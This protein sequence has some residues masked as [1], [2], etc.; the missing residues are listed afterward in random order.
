MQDLIRIHI[1]FLPFARVNF[2]PLRCSWTALCLFFI[3]WLVSE[4]KSIA[5]KHKSIR[6]SRARWILHS[7]I[8]RI[9][10]F[11]SWCMRMHAMTA[12]SINNAQY[13]F[14]QL[15]VTV[16]VR[17]INRCD[18]KWFIF[19]HI[20]FNI[21]WGFQFLVFFSP[22]KTLTHC[23]IWVT[24]STC[25]MTWK[26]AKYFTHLINVSTISRFNG[27]SWLFNKHLIYFPSWLISK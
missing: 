24:Y 7:F 4:Q 16:H 25:S 2:L 19:L 20:I 11:V 12:I 3:S 17:V 5:L 27:N 21:F 9:D 13:Y 18:Q 6:Q 26:T 14:G 10:I 8:E 22:I 23:Q 15:A 1:G